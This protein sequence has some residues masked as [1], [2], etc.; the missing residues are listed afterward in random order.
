MTA[1]EK[2]RRRLVQKLLLERAWKCSLWIVCEKAKF[3]S[4]IAAMRRK[5][6][7]YNWCHKVADRIEG[8]S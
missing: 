2:Q 6:R 7:T 5:G 1:C 8:E 3:D 4:D